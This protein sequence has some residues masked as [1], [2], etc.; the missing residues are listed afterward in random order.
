MLYRV[1]ILMFGE[2]AGVLYCGPCRVTAA[3]KYHE[4]LATDHLIRGRQTI[5][6]C[7]VLHDPHGSPVN[8]IVGLEWSRTEPW[9]ESEDP[10]KS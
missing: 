5:C 6:E 1:Y 10:V 8:P 9:F 4:H 3:S 7:A 2:T